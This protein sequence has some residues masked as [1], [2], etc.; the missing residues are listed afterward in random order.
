MDKINA[1]PACAIAA[2]NA[3]VVHLNLGGFISEY[4]RVYQSNYAIG[5]TSVL[6]EGRT[7][8]M[9]MV[10]L[11]CVVVPKDPED[12]TRPF[13]YAAVRVMVPRYM[14]GGSDPEA[15][16]F[17]CTFSEKQDEPDIT[18]TESAHPAWAWGL[19]V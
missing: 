15:R 5:H 4:Q 16:F 12:A 14:H 10:W 3:I 6:I 2:A 19:V 8:R 1:Q 11:L 7:N 18:I 9:M 17:E 13:P